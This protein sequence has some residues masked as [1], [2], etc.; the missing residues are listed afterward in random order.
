MR[1]ARLGV[2]RT[3]YPRRYADEAVV[4]ELHTLLADDAYAGRAAQIGEQVRAER[5]EKAACE[6][7][8]ALLD[9]GSARTG[10]RRIDR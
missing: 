7:I 2:S 1:V 6:A 3:L 10:A 8:E 4:R 9:G 5:G